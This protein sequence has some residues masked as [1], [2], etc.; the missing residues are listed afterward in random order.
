MDFNKSF[1]IICQCEKQLTQSGCDKIRAAADL[2][3]DIVYTRLNYLLPNE[4][5]FYHMTNLCYRTYTD[6]NKVQRAARKLNKN[7]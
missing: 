7:S 1:F 2:R 4:L 5:F 6:K 3:K